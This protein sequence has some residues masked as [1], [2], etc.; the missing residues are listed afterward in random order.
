F[1]TTAFADNRHDLTLLHLEAHILHG[2]HS[3]TAGAKDLRQ[4][5]CLKVRRLTVWRS[6]RWLYRCLNRRLEF[7]S[8]FLN[9][10]LNDTVANGWVGFQ[11]R[12]EQHPGVWVLRVVN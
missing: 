1:A 12:V 5:L 9:H 4:V 10:A 11:D 6:R 8:A 2:R 7:D 3:F